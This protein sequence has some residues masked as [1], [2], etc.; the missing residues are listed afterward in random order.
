MPWQ[1]WEIVVN[2]RCFPQS[3][4]NTTEHGSAQAIIDELVKTNR[5]CRCTLLI[6][7]V[8]RVP[9]RLSRCFTKPAIIDMQAMIKSPHTAVNLKTFPA[10]V[11]FIQAFPGNSSSSCLLKFHTE[12]IFSIFLKPMHY[13]MNMEEVCDICGGTGQLGIFRGLS[14]FIMTYEECPECYG[15]GIHQNDGDDQERTSTDAPANPPSDD[16]GNGNSTE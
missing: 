1:A 13:N 16:S 11:R 8:M 6:Q 7:Q 15:T 3:G 12:E 4:Y 2:A 14:R 9:R 5:A 10:K